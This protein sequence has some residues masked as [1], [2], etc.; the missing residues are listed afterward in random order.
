MSET[1]L[2]WLTTAVRDRR[3]FTMVEQLAA[4]AVA[5]TAAAAII[6]ATLMT[7][8]SHQF[9]TNAHGV[10][11]Y[12]AVAKM[13]S[14]ADFTRSRLFVDLSTDSYH[15]EIWQRTGTPGWVFEGG[16]QNLSPGVRFGFGSLATAPPDTQ[17]TLAMAPPCLDDSG[18]PIANTACIVFNSRG[19][20]IDATGTASSGALYLTNGVGVYGA[21]LSANSRL[22]LWW[23]RAANAAWMRTQ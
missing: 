17:A 5:V 6:P 22:Q 10:T 9:K 8:T 16:A 14:A 11:N 19:I 23:T 4:V 7:I 3:G 18:T 15:I 13:K 20:P 21:T 2:R 1:M 12:L